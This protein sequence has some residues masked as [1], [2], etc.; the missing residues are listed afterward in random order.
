MSPIGPGRSGRLARLR[1]AV[2]Q[3]ASSTASA[4]DLRSSPTPRTVLQAAVETSKAPI[5][6]VPKILRVIVFL[7]VQLDWLIIG[8]FGM[9]RKQKGPA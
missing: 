9:P 6:K 1:R 5:S 4:A 2:A 7:P 8:N 3:V